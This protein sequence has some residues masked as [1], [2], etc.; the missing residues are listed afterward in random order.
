LQ[1]VPPDY[2]CLPER[3]RKGV[4]KP[5]SRNLVKKR[6]TGKGRITRRFSGTRSLAG[7]GRTCGCIPLLKLDIGEACFAK[8]DRE[9]FAGGWVIEGSQRASNW[10]ESFTRIRG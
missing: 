3:K 6:G 8:L 7:E 9:G 10:Y 5:L 2:N 1:A 4:D